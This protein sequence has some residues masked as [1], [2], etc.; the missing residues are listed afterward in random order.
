MTAITRTT[1]RFLDGGAVLRA[2]VAGEALTNGDVVVADDTDNDLLQ[3]GADPAYY[4]GLVIDG[5]S[6][7]QAVTIACPGTL[8]VGY[9]LSGLS[10]GD[11]VYVQSNVLDDTSPGAV[12]N[13]VVGRVVYSQLGSDNKAVL[14]L[15]V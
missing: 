3:A 2:G 1:A 10:Y 12:N 8:I 4:E 6:A 5:A 15:F 14:L 7:G 13:I 9:D 11:P